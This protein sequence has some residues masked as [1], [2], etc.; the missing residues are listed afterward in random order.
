MG[1]TNLTAVNPQQQTQTT[2]P[3]GT[4]GFPMDIPGMF[5]RIIQRLGPGGLAKIGDQE[6]EL[7]RKSAEDQGGSVPPL[8]KERQSPINEIG[9]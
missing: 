7:L 3:M 1:A 9:R 4:Q 6:R 5:A 2:Q 8:D